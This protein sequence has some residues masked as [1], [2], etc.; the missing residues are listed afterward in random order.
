M[1]TGIPP[2]L[3]SL[4]AGSIGRLRGFGGTRQVNPALPIATSISLSPASASFALGKTQQFSAIV[5][6]QFGQNMGLAATWTSNSGNVTVGA[7][8]GLATG[9]AYGNAT[10]TATYQAISNTASATVQQPTKL[11]VVTQPSGGVSGSALT[12][13]PIIELR[14]ASSNQDAEVG[15]VVTVSLLAGVGTLTGVTSVATDTNGRAVFTN[16][17]I[18]ATT[19]PSSFT[20]AFASSGLTGINA[21]SV[22][23][24]LPGAVTQFF[25]STEPGG[26]GTNNDVL[27]ADDFS[28]PCPA[29][30]GSWCE[31][32][33]D[34][35]SSL[36]GGPLTAAAIPHT[37]GFGGTIFNAHPY[38]FLVRAITG[39]GSP[40]AARHGDMNGGQGADWMGDHN[41]SRGVTEFYSRF[42]AFFA[43]D[44]LFGAEKI[45]DINPPNWVGGGGIFWGNLHINLGGSQAT[46]GGLYWQGTIGPSYNTGF[47]FQRGHWYSVQLYCKMSSP[48]GTGNGILKVW[49]DD[50]GIDGTNVPSGGVPTLR[51]NRTDYPFAPA[52]GGHTQFG[53]IWCESWANPGSD[54]E[55][56]FTNV[57]VREFNGGTN[58]NSPILIRASS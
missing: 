17:T 39:R 20:L 53:S 55:W 48:I 50:L 30:G 54:Q 18:T 9:A 43:A 32:S 7:G 52:A 8:T 2:G 27:W 25:N 41:M 51:L 49:A 31:V 28:T 14:D 37:R 36:Y 16:L 19:P 56:V 58:G 6:D 15:R 23:V 35:A 10:L 26:D 33:F 1:I 57:M 24:T 13:Q 38:P 42:D 22:T 45:W 21:N 40:F 46:T 4:T 11:A 47:T 3:R 29:G 12:T 34:T 44:Y 5:R